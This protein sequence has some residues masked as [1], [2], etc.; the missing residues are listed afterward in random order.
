MAGP[1]GALNAL[2]ALWVG[3]LYDQGALDAAWDL[4]KDWSTAELNADGADE[5]MYLAPL[6]RAVASGQAPADELLAKWH[7][8]WKG[9]FAALFRDCAY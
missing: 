3:L 2:P 9:S 7:G 8:E 6:D 4:V 5:T 1:L